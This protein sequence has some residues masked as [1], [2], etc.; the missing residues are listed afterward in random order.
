MATIGTRLFTMMKGQYVGKDEFGNEYFHERKAPKDR[1][2]KR[3]VMYKGA[4]EPSKVPPHWHGW[5]HH[6]TDHVPVEGLPVKKHDWQKDHVPN[7]T[8][9]KARY[10]PQGHIL[11][12]GNRAKNVADYVAWK[13][14]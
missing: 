10:L 11:K 13:P 5:L 8:G 1:R 3:W 7:L 14:E 9:T 2:R 6:T 12:G 4:P